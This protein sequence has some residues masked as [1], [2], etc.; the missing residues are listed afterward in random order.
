MGFMEKLLELIPPHTLKDAVNAFPGKNMVIFKPIII[1]EGPFY[2]DYY[3]FVL[4]LNEVPPLTVEKNVFP[5]EKNKLFPINP[6]QVFGAVAQSE[7]KGYLTALINKDIIR[8][9]AHSAFGKRDVFLENAFTTIDDETWYLI[10]QYMRETS[11]MQKGYEFVQDGITMQ[12]CINLMRNLKSNLR[13]E[14]KVQGHPLNHIKKTIE[15]MNDCYNQDYSI[16]DIARIANLSPYHFIRVFKGETGMTPHEY[17]M[18]IK[19]GK[20]KEKLADKNLSISQ[21]FSLCGLDY[22]GHYAAV[23]KKIVGVTPSQYRKTIAR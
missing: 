11:N 3:Q 17:M 20:I 23:F 12:L 8:E 4:T 18:N 5:I 7:V 2:S 21:A 13:L 10:K 9:M 1:F 6:D 22:N 19:I 14:K 16:E 15:F